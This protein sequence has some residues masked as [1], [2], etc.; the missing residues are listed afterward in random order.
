MLIAVRLYVGHISNG[1]NCFTLYDEIFFLHRLSDLKVH[2]QAQCLALADGSYL[3]SNA[4]AQAP[5]AYRRWFVC[6][7]AN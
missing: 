3:G 5:P 6:P 7:N 2:H 1:T 4:V